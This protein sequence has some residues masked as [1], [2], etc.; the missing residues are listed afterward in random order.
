MK[1]IL[2]YV[3]EYKFRFIIPTIS[4]IIIVALAMYTPH[5]M[6]L[7]IDKVV[8]GREYDLLTNLLIGL[9]A[10]TVGRSIFGFIQEYLFDIVGAQIA[11]DIRRD[12][13][14]HIQNLSF[15][16][17][18]KTNTG[19]IMS[20]TTG[21]IGNIWMVTGFVAVFFT[22][23]ILYFTLGAIMIFST[24]WRLATIT[25]AF[26]PIIA[27]LAIKLD[28][29]VG[30]V[31]EEI[32]DQDA[33][34]NTTAQENI[35][36]VRLVKAFG[37]EKHEVSKFL[38]ENKQKYKLNVKRVKT[39]VKYQPIIELITNVVIIIVVC[40]GGV[41]VIRNELT[42][43]SLV[44]FY[45]YVMLMIWP[46]RMLG[47]LINNL[48]QCNASAKKI[49]KIMDIKSSI[50]SPQNPLFPKEEVGNIVFDRVSLKYD[51]SVVLNDVSFEVKA[52][53]TIAIM[54]TTGSGK[55]SIANLIARYYDCTE[56]EILVDGINIKQRELANLRSQ[57]SVVM[58]DTFL[59]SDTI[60]A[61]IKFG[62]NE[63]GDEEM[64]NVSKLA[65]VHGFV[66]TMSDKYDTVIGERGV[67]LSGGQKQRI[68]IARALL[69]EANVLILDDATSSLDT[70]TEF[71]IQKGLVKL[72]TLTKVII[73]HRISAVKDA[74]EIILLENGEIIE[75]GNH[76][77]LLKKQGRYHNIFKEQYG[78][79]EVIKNE[80]ILCQ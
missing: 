19:E 54:G 61:N 17:F 14:T 75:R 74:D 62:H 59:F 79:I 49:F 36:G 3:M 15:G 29:E 12:L 45:G 6:K 56:G 44:A 65:K 57:I 64:I 42:L 30:K 8:I 47:F 2:K 52:G 72:K 21:D 28:K 32:S 26:M 58:Q 60:S 46:M 76:K 11:Q 27:Y 13:F 33:A 77:S 24:E 35:A 7:I 37:R 5:V 16:F 4:M 34:L 23:Q 63:I 71:D 67:G 22:Q 1:R 66:E 20:R 51:N 43:G 78:D 48:A 80:V 69:K 38:K 50:T 39:W 55:S 68:A 18:D 25:L 73:A 31:Y 41:M 53:K 40:F 70:E 10:I 9:L